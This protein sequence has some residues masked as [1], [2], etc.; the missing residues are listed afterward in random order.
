[1]EVLFGTSPAFEEVELIFALVH[2]STD[3]V[4]L[5]SVGELAVS[6]LIVE[7]GVAVVHVDL[8]VNCFF[9]EFVG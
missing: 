4:V 9:R 3:S 1:M 8:R 5:E 6:L 7:V 2:H